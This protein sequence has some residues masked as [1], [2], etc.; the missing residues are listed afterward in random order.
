MLHEFGHGREHASSRRGREAV[1]PASVEGGASQ[2][3]GLGQPNSP[4][5]ADGRIL[6]TGQDVVMHPRL[7]VVDDHRVA[8]FQGLVNH[9]LLDAFLCPAEQRKAQGR[10]NSNLVCHGK[11]ELR[12]PVC[13]RRISEQCVLRRSSETQRTS[14]RNSPREKR[15]LGSAGQRLPGHPQRGVRSI[16]RLSRAR[17]RSSAAYLG[18]DGRRHS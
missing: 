3:A 17:H 1:F 15:D 11:P 9:V 12:H 10:R 7:T 13:K 6:D 8:D 18:P 14:P 16:E 4:L 2:V 5:P